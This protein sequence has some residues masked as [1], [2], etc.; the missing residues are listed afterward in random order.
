MA[1]TSRDR[2]ALAKALATGARRV[3]FQTHEVEYRSQQD[4]RD[5]LAEMDTQLDPASA[6]VRR[7]AA[8]YNSG[9]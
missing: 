1:W 3:R 4:M 6:P 9:L 5:L 8:E 7:T 2:D